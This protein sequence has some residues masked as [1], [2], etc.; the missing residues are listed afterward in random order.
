MKLQ[1]KCERKFVR[2]LVKIGNIFVTL[3][4]L[5]FRKIL[6]RGTRA[7]V[8]FIE[9][10]IKHDCQVVCKLKGKILFLAISLFFSDQDL[11]GIAHSFGLLRL[12]AMKELRGRKDMGNFQSARI[13][14]APVEAT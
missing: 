12:P 6:L 3:R 4:I 13:A 5:I 11:P 14:P 7:F 1:L 2:L 8:S 10:Y 9:F